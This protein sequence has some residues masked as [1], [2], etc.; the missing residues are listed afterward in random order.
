MFFQQLDVIYEKKSTI[1]TT[2]YKF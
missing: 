2:K 1:L